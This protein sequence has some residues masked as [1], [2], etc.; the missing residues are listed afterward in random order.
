MQVSEWQARQTGRRI[1]LSEFNALFKAGR[2][3]DAKISSFGDGYGE[4]YQP[5]RT[6][7]GILDGQEIVWTERP[8]REEEGGR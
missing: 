2:L 3:T 5:V 1:K 6:C 7:W 4:P 8:D